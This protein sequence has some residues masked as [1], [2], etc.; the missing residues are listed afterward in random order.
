MYYS[1][2]EILKRSINNNE[3]QECLRGN[4]KYR[5][6]DKND[7]GPVNQ[8]IVLDSIYKIY[9]KE[10][11]VKIDILFQRSLCDMINSDV[12]GIYLVIYYLYEQIGNEVKGVSP[13]KIDRL[14]FKSKVIDAIKNN[15]IEIDNTNQLERLNVKGNILKR[16]YKINDFSIKKYGVSIL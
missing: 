4:G 14:L 13:F 16:I 2:Y 15:K 7:P 5:Y 3:L 11:D 10:P 9:E 8:S 12:E 6:Q 1:G